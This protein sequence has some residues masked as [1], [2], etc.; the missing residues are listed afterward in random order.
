[1]TLI[2]RGF[3]IGESAC[4]EQ[5]DVEKLLRATVPT[6]RTV[7]AI[8]E[9]HGDGYEFIELRGPSRRRLIRGIASTA[10]ISQ[11]GH[12]YRPMGC[13]MSLPLPLLFEHGGSVAKK[14]FNLEKLRIGELVLVHKSE[15]YVV[16]EAVLD[17]SDAADHAWSFVEKGE[18]RCLSVASADAKLVGV[19]DDVKFYDQW[20]LTEVSVCRAGANPDAIFHVA[21]N[22]S[23][24]FA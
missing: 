15:K 8:R 23:V 13:I 21:G 9:V 24:D 20:R 3:Q 14:E 18:A 1:M 16:V 4:G 12:S 22:Y 17:N 5:F 2:E 10:T 19:V 7:R 11:N 6:E